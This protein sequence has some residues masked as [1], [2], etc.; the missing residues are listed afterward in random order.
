MPRMLIQ[1]VMDFISAYSKVI[2]FQIILTGLGSIM[3]Q[4]HIGIGEAVDFYKILCLNS[5]SLNI[6]GSPSQTSNAGCVVLNANDGT[7]TNQACDTPQ[8]YICSY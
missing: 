6:L 3:I 8:C 4:M 2:I 5:C 1:A 7:W